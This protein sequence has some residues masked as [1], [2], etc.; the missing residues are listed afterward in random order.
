MA[1]SFRFALPNRQIFLGSA[2]WFVVHVGR[3]GG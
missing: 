3:C 1:C 2:G